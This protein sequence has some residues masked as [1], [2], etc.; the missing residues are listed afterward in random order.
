MWKHPRIRLKSSPWPQLLLTMLHPCYPPSHYSIVRLPHN[1]SSSITLLKGHN[2]AHFPTRSYSQFVDIYTGAHESSPH[3]LS[4]TPASI[5]SAVH[6][7]WRFGLWKFNAI[8]D[9][10]HTTHETVCSISGGH[11]D[12]QEEHHIWTRIHM[13]RSTTNAEGLLW[14]DF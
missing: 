4:T 2:A 6:W 3:Y 8:V 13:T 5:T 1:Q 10:V 11:T 9:R 7:K 12:R 14:S